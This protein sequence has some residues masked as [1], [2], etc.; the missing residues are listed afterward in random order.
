LLTA[1]IVMI[2]GHVLSAQGREISNAVIKMMDYDGNLTYLVTNPYG[3]F[4]KAN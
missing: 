3:Y 2:L 4:R 1:A